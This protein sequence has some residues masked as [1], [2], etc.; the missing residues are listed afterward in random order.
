MP[1]PHFRFSLQCPLPELDFDRITLGHGS[2]GLLT[3]QLL[4][5]VCL[6]S[7]KVNSYSNVMMA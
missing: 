5:T 3:N 7:S 4:D 6:P 2:G 1:D